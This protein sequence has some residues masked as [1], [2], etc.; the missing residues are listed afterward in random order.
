MKQGCG[1][2]EKSLDLAKLC[3]AVGEGN[4]VCNHKRVSNLLSIFLNFILLCVRICMLYLF[5]FELLARK[6]EFSD[7]LLG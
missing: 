3:I 5:Y 6:C 7:G 1:V 4:A 2:S